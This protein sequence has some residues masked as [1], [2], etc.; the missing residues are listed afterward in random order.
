MPRRKLNGVLL[1]DLT[2]DV[3]ASSADRELD[4]DGEGSFSIFV[5]AEVCFVLDEALCVSILTVDRPDAATR[6]KNPG[7]PHGEKGHIKQGLQMAGH[8]VILLRMHS[9]Y[10]VLTPQYLHAAL[11]SLYRLGWSRRR[12]Y[13]KVAGEEERLV[14][15][16]LNM[17]E[18]TCNIQVQACIAGLR[19]LHV[20]IITA[21]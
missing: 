2:A 1:P 18:S 7:R 5:V 13:Q 20:R 15:H 17:K 3:P 6:T 14:L 16:S 4:K 10:C 11:L 8:C 9:L 19:A 21:A 12:Q